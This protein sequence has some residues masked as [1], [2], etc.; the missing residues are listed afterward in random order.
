MNSHVQTVIDQITTA[1]PGEPEFLQAVSEA[2]GSL[3]PVL[4]RH[5]EYR[6]AKLLERMAEPERA[7]IF[8]V[9][10][11][12]DAG[13]GTGQPGIPGADEQRHRAVQGRAA[14]P[15]DGAPR[16]AEV[17]RLR[18]GVQERAHDAA[19]GRR[20]GRLGLRSE[21]QERCRGPAVL[22]VVH[23]R[24]VPAHRP[25]HRRPRRRH[26]RG[27]PG[28]RLPLRPVQADHE[29]VQRGASPARAMA[30][31]APASGRRRPATAPCT[32]PRRCSPPGTRPSRARPAW[33]RGAAT[34]P[35]TPRRS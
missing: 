1:N 15:P 5:S 3:G 19:D 25:V 32:S 8:R 28:D 23:D 17:P 10:W 22:P 33:S 34:S 4:D 21:G 27:R 14:V 29:P 7:I 16:A 2:Y 18:A 30:G 9:P 20:Q 12:D 24:A 6:D 13:R 35:S 11:V 31:A 26:R